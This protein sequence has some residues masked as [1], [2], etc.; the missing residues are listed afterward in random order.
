MPLEVSAPAVAGSLRDSVSAVASDSSTP[1]TIVSISDIHGYL[2]N[3]Q[4]ALLTLTEHPEYDPVVTEDEQG[5]LHWAGNDYVLVFNGDLIDRGANNEGVLAMVS[6]LIEDAPAGRVR[7]TLGNHEWMVLMQDPFRGYGWF[8]TLVSEAQ[9]RQYIQRIYDGHVVA[10]YSGHSVSYAHAGS[11][12]PYD[13]PT[14]NDSLVAAARELDP[15]LGTNE[16][17]AVAKKL[18]KEYRTVLGTGDTRLKGPTAGLVWMHFQ[19]HT[20]DSPPQ[21]VGH[22]RQLTP[23]S[24]G[25]VYCQDLLLDNRGSLGGHGVFVETPESLVALTRRDDGGVKR[26]MLSEAAE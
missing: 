3:A 13:V 8:S 22:S 24:T 11:T 25:E 6:R 20:S 23:Q 18:Q 7:V 1:P 16:E 15:A 2:E 19:H 21:V 17:S 4:E 12:T 5:R 26:T 9:Q 14:V 10:A